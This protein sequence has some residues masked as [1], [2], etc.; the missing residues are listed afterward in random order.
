MITVECFCTGISCCHRKVHRQQEALQGRGMCHQ[1]HA[2]FP[3]TISL[4]QYMRISRCMCWQCAT[5]L[6]ADT[7]L[8]LSSLRLCSSSDHPIIS[9]FIENKDRSDCCPGETTSDHT[10]VRVT[11]L[12]TLFYRGQPVKTALAQGL[13]TEAQIAIRSVNA[14][15]VWTERC[16]MNK[17]RLRVCTCHCHLRSPGDASQSCGNLLRLQ[18]L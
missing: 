12:F 6:L 18:R 14:R 8:T 4:H 10:S 2:A 1:R 3:H 15:P 13:D 5:C 7:S 16:W 9:E 11:S 17:L